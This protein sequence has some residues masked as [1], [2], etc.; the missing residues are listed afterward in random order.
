MICITQLNIE[1]YLNGELY[2]E[3]IKIDKILLNLAIQIKLKNEA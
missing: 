2:Y 1:K 3:W